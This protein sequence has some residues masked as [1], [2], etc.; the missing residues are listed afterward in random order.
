MT[1][2]TEKPEDDANEE[3]LKTFD[4]Y[5]FFSRYDVIA[6]ILVVLGLLLYV[7]YTFLISPAEP[8]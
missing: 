2:Q 7:L 4:M 6:I 5:R 1:N 3:V 8:V